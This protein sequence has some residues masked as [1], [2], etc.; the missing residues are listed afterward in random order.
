MS[1]SIIVGSPHLCLLAIF[2]ASV[3]GPPFPRYQQ[4]L[5][6]HT[7]LLSVGMFCDHIFIPCAPLEDSGRFVR[8]LRHMN[9]EIRIFIGSLAMAFNVQIKDSDGGTT[10][11][12][13][14]K[15]LN[16][17]PSL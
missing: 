10:P 1:P 8:G 9:E 14:H 6:K 17:L 13:K 12:N 2:Q 15:L 5:A 16:S 11:G 7:F 3:A 4:V